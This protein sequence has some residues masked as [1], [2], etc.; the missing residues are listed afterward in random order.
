MCRQ[1]LCLIPNSRQRTYSEDV[2]MWSVAPASWL[3]RWAASIFIV[4][5]KLETQPSLLSKDN[6]QG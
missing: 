6:A 4:T 1:L 2:R 5:C 3:R